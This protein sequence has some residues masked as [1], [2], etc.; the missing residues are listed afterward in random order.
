MHT[1]ESFILRSNEEHYVGVSPLLEIFSQGLVSC[2]PLDYM[3]LCCLGIM[4]TILH[5]VV[6]GSYVP[7]SCGSTLLSKDQ[8]EKVNDRMDIIK[9]WLCENFAR[10]PQNLN[11]FHTYKATE[12]CQIMIK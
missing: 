7:N 4:K 8:I 12:F 11:K 2:I 5:F 6:R 9:Q 10:I 3:H 1:D